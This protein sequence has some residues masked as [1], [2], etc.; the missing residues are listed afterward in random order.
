MWQATHW[1]PALRAGT[2]GDLRGDEYPLSEFETRGGCFPHV[3]N[4]ANDFVTDGGACRHRQ[5][6]A[7]IGDIKIA[8][9]NDNWTH[10]GFAGALQYRICGFAPCDLPCFGKYCV[11]HDD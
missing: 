6:A 7:Y 11:A 5:D 8:A 4:L 3:H 10:Q 1:L 9:T 2:A